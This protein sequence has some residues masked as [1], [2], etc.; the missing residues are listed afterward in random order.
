[1]PQISAFMHVLHVLGPTFIFFFSF[2]RTWDKKRI[3]YS[4]IYNVLCVLFTYILLV[5]KY[6]IYYF[7][8]LSLSFISHFKLR[9]IKLIAWAYPGHAEWCKLLAHEWLI[10]Y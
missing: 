4:I 6:Q 10:K 2:S 3:N 5:I 7:D 8:T 1:M 9:S